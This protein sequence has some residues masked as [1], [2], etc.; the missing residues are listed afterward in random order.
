MIK[1]INTLY[2]KK[3]TADNV[4]ERF[5]IKKTIHT[6]KGF[7]FM[8]VLQKENSETYDEVQICTT[9]EN[10]ESFERWKNSEEFR[11]AH[12]PL[13]QRMRAGDDTIIDSNVSIFKIDV[14]RS[15]AS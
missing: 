1:A 5:K 3:G 9:W 7:V 14:Q 12:V 15:P 6:F 11:T 10:V 4:I 13:K 8:E 2:L